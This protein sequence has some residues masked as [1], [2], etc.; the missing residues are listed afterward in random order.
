MLVSFQHSKIGPIHLGDLN[1]KKL[2]EE[3]PLRCR[4]SFKEN[5]SEEAVKPFVLGAFPKSISYYGKSILEK[6][7]EQL[8]DLKSFARDLIFEIVRLKFFPEKPCRMVSFLA[9]SSLDLADHMRCF[10]IN[11]TDYKQVN[12][13]E[14]DWPQGRYHVG[15]INWLEHIHTLAG[16]IY[17]ARHYWAGHERNDA[18]F[19]KPVKE[20]VIADDVTVLRLLST[21]DKAKLLGFKDK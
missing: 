2:I 17:N 15:D 20:F 3:E 10:G 18:Y 12:V 19:Y 1:F 16:G 4:C 8:G 7:F 9:C 11:S 6:P 14:I 21:E 5:E 13:A